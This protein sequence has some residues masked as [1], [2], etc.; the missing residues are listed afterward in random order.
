MKYVDINKRFTE[1][2]AEYIG[3]GYVLNTSTMGGS[4]GEIAKVDLTDGI[5]IIRIYI[6]SFHEW[7]EHTEGLEI[8]VGRSQTAWVIPNACNGHDVIWCQELEVL[9]SERFYQLGSNRSGAYYGTKDEAVTAANR[10]HERYVN[11]NSG[12]RTVNLTAKAMEI[13]KR[14]IRREF[15]VKRICEADVKVFKCDGA[16]MVSYKGK[17]YRLR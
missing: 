8:I 14:I 1:I 6:D 9:N 10:R 17:T 4:Q 11:R 7:D 2:V 15:G 16:Y 12:R 3:K 13:G 5:E